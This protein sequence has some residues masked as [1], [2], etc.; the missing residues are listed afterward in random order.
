LY[1][2]Q[3]KKGISKAFI[4]KYKSSDRIYKLT[5]GQYPHISLDKARDITT[6]YNSILQSLEFKEKGLSLKDYLQYM[7]DKYKNAKI[8]FKYVFTE[9][10]EKQSIRETTKKQYMAF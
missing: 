5:L 2:R 3:N 7:Q 1:L 9:W 8:T 4:F 6:E 10:I